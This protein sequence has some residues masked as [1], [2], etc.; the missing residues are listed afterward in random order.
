MEIAELVLEESDGGKQRLWDNTHKHSS[1]SHLLL[2]IKLL[3]SV[4]Y[5]FSTDGCLCFPEK[6]VAVMMIT[7]QAGEH[8]F[9]IMTEI[10][11][12]R[13]N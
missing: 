10:I 3:N 4:F 2:R 7:S 13:I 11:C 12:C 5:S 1:I 6:D 8:T 9:E